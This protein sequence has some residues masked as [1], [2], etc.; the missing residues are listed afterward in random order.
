MTQMTNHCVQSHVTCSV[1]ASF[2]LLGCMYSHSV[3]ALVLFLQQWSGNNSNS[4]TLKSSL[5]YSLTFVSYF[6]LMS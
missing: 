3:N 1:C 2:F 6:V 5:S 4:I